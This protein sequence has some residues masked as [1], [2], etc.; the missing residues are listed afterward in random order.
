MLTLIYGLTLTNI[1]V[2]KCKKSETK[3]IIYCNSIISENCNF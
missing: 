1:W 2:A 3:W